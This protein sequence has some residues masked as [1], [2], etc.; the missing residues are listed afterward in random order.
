M[1]LF[2]TMFFTSMFFATF[3]SSCLVAA[4]SMSPLA[5]VKATLLDE[6][7]RLCKESADAS[8]CERLGFEFSSE[9]DKEKSSRFFALS[10]DYGVQVSCL[11]AGRGFA[12]INPELSKKYLT[13]AC[14]EGHFMAACLSIGMTEEEMLIFRRSFSRKHSSPISSESL[15]TS[16][17]EKNTTA[18]QHKPSAS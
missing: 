9:K 7:L 15:P 13:L 14:H 12:G 5:Q 8:A 18:S 2:K 11:R 1:N 16:N 17:K 6:D 10:C 3:F 4:E